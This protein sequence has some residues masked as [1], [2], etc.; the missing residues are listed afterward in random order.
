MPGT[1]PGMTGKTGGAYAR[2]N[3]LRRRAHTARSL[4]AQA[5]GA[6]K[7]RHDG[8]DP[9]MVEDVVMGCVDPVGEAGA[10]IARTAA[11]VAG[12]G[13][14]VPGLQVTRFC[15]SGLDAVNFAAA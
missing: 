3:H 4:A 11:L 1:S 13:D 8:R 15:A 14:Q 5:R 6:I 10:D 2:R 9:N 12:S 7:E